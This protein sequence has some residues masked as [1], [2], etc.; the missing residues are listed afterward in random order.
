MLNQDAI[1][2]IDE[3]INLQVSR[4]VTSIPAQMLRPGSGSQ[5]VNLGFSELA[6]GFNDLFRRQR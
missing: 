3:T 4:R 2:Q 5:Q 6:K 1:V